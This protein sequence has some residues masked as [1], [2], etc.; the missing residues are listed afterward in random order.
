MRKSILI[1]V[2]AALMLF[3]FT[4]CEPQTVTWPTTK[5][6]SYLSIEQVKSFVKG[7]VATDDGFNAVIHYTDGSSE[8]APGIAEV[9]D[10]NVTVKAAITFSG[11]ANPTTAK[12]YKIQFDTVT[13][14]SITGASN[15]QIV[16]G[17]KLSDIHDITTAVKNKVLS[18]SGD[19]VFTFTSENGTKSFTLADEVAGKFDY[20]LSVFEDD[21]TTPMTAE[22]TFAKGK[23]YS[24]KVTGYE[25]AD[26]TMYPVDFATDLTISVVDATQS[27]PVTITGLEV[28]YSVTGK[29]DVNGTITDAQKV[30]T[31]GTLAQLNATDLYFGDSVTYTVKAVYS[32]NTAEK[33]HKQS[34]TYS[35]TFGTENSYQII[36]SSE[37]FTDGTQS[38]KTTQQTA[39]IRF[40][41]DSTGEVYT[42]NITIP[43]G[44]VTITGS[45]ESVAQD[46]TKNI[47]EGTQI[48]EN[49]I[50]QYV[51]VSG[52]TVVGRT[53]ATVVATDYDI[54]LPYGPVTLAKEGSN[55]PVVL[56]YDSYG[57]T[58]RK[59]VSVPFEVVSTN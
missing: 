40:Y 58:V 21:S 44:D 35:A 28:L 34:L 18:F 57:T 46:K 7:E 4:A 22:N 9:Q 30:L 39:A 53:P 14:I 25:L 52:L 23:T 32:D 1:G 15:V 38:V 16:A 49:N 27:A 50:N 2:L 56:T 17:T 54:L 37:G 51:T 20:Q 48:T 12:D 8:V 55:V 41:D 31:N 11:D 6:V 36:S 19:P 24:V 13:D 43:V 59:T 42:E 26:G 33:E 47:A 5:D 10:D 3:A 29:R 45:R